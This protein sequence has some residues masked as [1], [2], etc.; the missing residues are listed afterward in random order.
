MGKKCY[1]GELLL[2]LINNLDIWENEGGLGR[3]A[4][5]L[6]RM[7]TSR[8]VGHLV[9]IQCKPHHLSDTTLKKK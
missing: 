7:R 8:A 2:G 6:S 5:M 3:W 1:F 4:V 9:D